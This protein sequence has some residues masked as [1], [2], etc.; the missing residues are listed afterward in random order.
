LAQNGKRMPSVAGCTERLAWP[1][2]CDRMGSAKMTSTAVDR[3]AANLFI[4]ILDEKEA[5]NLEL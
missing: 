5:E 1:L 2:P 4:D 3:C